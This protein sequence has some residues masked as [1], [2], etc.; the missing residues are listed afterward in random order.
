MRG[1]AMVNAFIAFSGKNFFATMG[2]NM[3]KQLL[4]SF[5]K[6]AANAIVV[7]GVFDGTY[8]ELISEKFNPSS[9]FWDW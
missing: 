5:G 6:E 9:D 7:S 4:L 3:S 2:A 1:N 8:S